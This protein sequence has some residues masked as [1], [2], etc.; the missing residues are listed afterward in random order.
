MTV[1]MV[2]FVTTTAVNIILTI[3]IVI[4]AG[5]VDGVNGAYP[6]KFRNCFAANFL[7]ERVPVEIVAKILGHSSP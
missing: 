5:L 3:V 7:I 2:A 1:I 4:L 6:H